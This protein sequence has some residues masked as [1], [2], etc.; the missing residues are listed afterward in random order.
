MKKRFLLYVTSITPFCLWDTL[1]PLIVYNSSLDKKE[2][3][4]VYLSSL[5]KTAQR[6]C[7]RGLLNSLFQ[8]GEFTI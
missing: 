2:L 1:T 7:E 5:K 3:E 6:A 8:R 4:R